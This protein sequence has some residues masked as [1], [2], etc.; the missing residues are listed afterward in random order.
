L[1]EHKKAILQLKSRKIK[2]KMHLN[3]EIVS[4]KT[5]KKHKKL[6]SRKLWKLIKVYQIQNSTTKE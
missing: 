3:F 1:E 4:L 6:I 5:R 2:S